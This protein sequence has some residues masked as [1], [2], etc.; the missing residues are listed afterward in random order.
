[1]DKYEKL[2]K[3]KDYL[4]E[5]GSVAVAFSG[6]VDSTFLLKVAHDVLGDKAIAVTASSESFPEREY[7]EAVA[8]CEKECIRQV[9]CESS[10]LAIEGFKENPVDRCYICKKS[11]FG[12]ILQVAAANGIAY[13]AEGSN[14]DD[15][16][17]YRPGLR[18]IAELNILSFT[19][20][21]I[22]ETAD[23]FR[24]STSPRFNSSLSTPERFIAVL[25]P[26]RAV[27]VSLP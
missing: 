25:C 22:V 11:I 8:F 15:N 26:A 13:V 9:V 19:S 2:E 18:A 20:S 23:P 12:D 21:I 5:K 14:M 10:E 27:S 4:R 16:G 7:K 17:D 3:L 24:A 1:M 6:G